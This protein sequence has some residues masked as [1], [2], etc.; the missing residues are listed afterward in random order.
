MNFEETKILV[1]R[2]TQGQKE[3]GQKVM[4]ERG[5]ALKTHLTN[6]FNQRWTAKKCLC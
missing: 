4:A 2:I 5:A 6:W 1:E 3:I